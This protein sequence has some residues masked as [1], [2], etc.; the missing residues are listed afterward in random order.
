MPNMI[1]KKHEHRSVATR[2]SGFILW[3]DIDSGND[4][5][6]VKKNLSVASL[7]SFICE[8]EE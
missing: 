7:N 2:N 4:K 5:C 6:E 8:T 1:E 3:Y